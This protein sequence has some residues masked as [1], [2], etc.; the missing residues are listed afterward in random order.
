MFGGSG[1]T[2]IA[3]EQLKRKAFSM[4]LMKSMLM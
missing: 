4:E 3:A 2:L 1:S